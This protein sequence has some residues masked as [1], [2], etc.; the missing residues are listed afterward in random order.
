MAIGEPATALV[1]AD[2]RVLFGQRVE[3]VAPDRTA[4][5]ELQMAHP[6]GRLDERRP[7]TRD[8]IRQT[9]A[10]RAGA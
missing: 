6:V 8:R 1:I 5:I 4:D 2:Q 7:A 9:Y 10:V 3:H